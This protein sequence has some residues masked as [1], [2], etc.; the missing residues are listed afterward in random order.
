MA[1]PI[2]F[3]L[4]TGNVNKSQEFSKIIDNKYPVFIVEPKFEPIEPQTWDKMELINYKLDQ[5]TKATKD[6][7]GDL[8]NSYLVVEDVSF[9]V[10][11]KD[12]SDKCL[13]GPFIKYFIE[14][15]N[16]NDFL[17]MYPPKSE[18]MEYVVYAAEHIISK[19]RFYGIGIRSGIL[20]VI[21][22]KN[23]FG[24]DPIFYVKN[25]H[26]DYVSVASLSSEDKNKFSGRAL[27]IKN[28]VQNIEQN[29][30]RFKS[31]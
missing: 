11:F 18:A 1:Y 20:D 30:R 12:D 16:L 7:I 9:Y 24:Y 15:M 5:A 13:P 8:Q 14:A 31:S 27:A 26:D 3:L 4:C 22:G 19:Q 28:L 23:G 10:N 25:N 2:S 29:L 21:D 17:K 6:N